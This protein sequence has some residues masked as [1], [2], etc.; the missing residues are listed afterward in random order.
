MNQNRKK[1]GT[2]KTPRDKKSTVS[3]YSL[4]FVLSGALVLSVIIIGALIF[5]SPA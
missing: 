2:G 3:D 5:T 1:K 4:F